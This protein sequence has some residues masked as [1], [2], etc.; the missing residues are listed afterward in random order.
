MR[1]YDELQQFSSLI[2]VSS[3]A[4][5]DSGGALSTLYVMPYLFETTNSF[6]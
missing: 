5:N 2:I 1:L 4:A 6:L 3:G